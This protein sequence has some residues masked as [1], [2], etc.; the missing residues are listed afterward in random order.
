[1]WRSSTPRFTRRCRHRPTGTRS[2]GRWPMPTGSAATA[3]TAHPTRSSSR[4]PRSSWA[5]PSTQSRVIT[6]HLGNGASAC[7]V[8]GGRSIDTSMGLTPLAGLVMGT[9][10][11][12][13]DPGMLLHLLRAGLTTDELDALLNKQ[14]GMKGLTGTT[15]CEQVHAAADAGDAA[16]GLP[17]RSTPTPC[18]HYLG[19]YLVELGGAD[20]I[21]FTA[22]V[23]E[24]DAAVRAAVCEGLGGLGIEVDP[25][26]N[27]APAARTR[28]S[29]SP[30]P[31]PACGCWWCRPTRNSRS[32][33]SRWP[34]CGGSCWRG[35]G[36]RPRVLRA[37][38]VPADECCAVA[39]FGAPNRQPCN[40]RGGRG[41]T[42]NSRAPEAAP[43]VGHPGQHL[44]EPPSRRGVP[45]LS[46]PPVTLVP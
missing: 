21:V 7:A 27:E 45:V 11:G 41:T 2:T 3:S 10:S 13:V 35:P 23:G 42:C 34:R 25:V 5:S 17:W 14:S 6:L 9:R 19:A 30:R 16:A 4:G 1:M 46:D 43:E 31:V 24:N 28:W 22:G 36:P 15:T 26:R 32:P 8:A 39:G 38:L 12:D 33:G 20:A 40:S 37:L 18:R 29:T 44:P